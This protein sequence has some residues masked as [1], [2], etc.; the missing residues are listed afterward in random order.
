MIRYSIPESIKYQAHQYQEIISRTA[1]LK[2][3]NYTGLNE[4]DRYANGYIGE[5]AF[6]E[7]CKQ[8]NIPYIHNVR[9]DGKA[10][11]ADFIIKDK[12][13]DMKLATKSHYQRCMMPQNQFKKHHRDFYIGARLF[14]ENLIDLIGYIPRRDLEDIQPLDFGKGVPTVAIYLSNLIDIKQLVNI[15]Q[16]L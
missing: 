9:T 2:T 13:F 11:G 3:R 4:P 14:D 1:T 6:E 15:V 5:W 12:L 10:D 7:F 8:N 16:T